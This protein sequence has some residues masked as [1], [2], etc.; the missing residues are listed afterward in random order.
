MGRDL[1]LIIRLRIRLCLK[2]VLEQKFQEE[3]N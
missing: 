1:S 3:K 2:I